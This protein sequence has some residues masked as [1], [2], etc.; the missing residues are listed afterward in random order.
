M[1]FVPYEIDFRIKSITETKKENK[2]CEITTYKLVGSD[3]EGENEITITSAM[4]FV[5]LSAKTGI[6]QVAIK[7][8]QKTLKDFEHGIE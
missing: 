6:I 1:E 8:S 7:N 3:K 2:D 5:G 4:P